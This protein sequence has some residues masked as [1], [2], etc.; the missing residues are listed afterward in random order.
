LYPKL[1]IS[2]VLLM[3]MPLLGLAQTKTP[4]D[5]LVLLAFALLWLVLVGLP[6]PLL[7]LLAVG[8]IVALILVGWPLS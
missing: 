2:V 7:L 6:Q 5:W 3:P 1:G 8:A 4:L